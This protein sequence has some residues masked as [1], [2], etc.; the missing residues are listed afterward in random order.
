MKNKHF[1]KKSKDKRGKKD[2]RTSY[3]ELDKSQRVKEADWSCRHGGGCMYCEKNRKF[4]RRKQEKN[5][6]NQLDD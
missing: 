6:E 3:S 4:R 5:T 2:W 1:T